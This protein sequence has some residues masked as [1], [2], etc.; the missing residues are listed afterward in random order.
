[1]IASAGNATETPMLRAAPGYRS[2]ATLANTAS[3]L[4]SG[5]FGICNPATMV[6]SFVY[7]D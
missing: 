3:R 5:N 6:F 4:K 2:S 1:M 7:L